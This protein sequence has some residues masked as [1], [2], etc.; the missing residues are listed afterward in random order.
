M[1]VHDNLQGNGLCPCSHNFNL[2]YTGSRFGCALWEE[3]GGR[4]VSCHGCGAGVTCPGFSAR[5]LGVA[6]RRVPQPWRVLALEVGQWK[7]PR[8]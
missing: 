7:L 6:V 1:T 3:G 4:A 2:S 8:K 5:A